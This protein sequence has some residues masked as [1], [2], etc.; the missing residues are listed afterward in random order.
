MANQKVFLNSDEIRN[1]ANSISN[2]DARIMDILARFEAEMNR[3]ESVWESEAEDAMRENF[4]ALKP[5]FEKF[6][7]YN[8]KVVTHLK[9]NV[10]DARD[11]LDTA[12]KNNASSL[13]RTV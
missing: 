3:I 10:A 6:H 1:C 4:N 9:T 5:A 12:L 7:R 2:Y 11:A 8:E 13:K